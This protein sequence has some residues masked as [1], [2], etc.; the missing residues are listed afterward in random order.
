MRRLRAP[1]TVWCVTDG[2]G[3]GIY[4][5]HRTR[6]QARMACY[7]WRSRAVRYVLAGIK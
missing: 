1:K 5:V 7:F 6:E 2:D 3:R 4:S